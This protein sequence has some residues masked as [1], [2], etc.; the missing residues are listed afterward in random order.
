MSANLELTFQFI[1]NITTCMYTCTYIS[2]RLKT[3]ITDNW[4]DE[5]VQ[6]LNNIVLPCYNGKKIEYILRMA[7]Y[8]EAFQYIKKVPKWWSTDIQ[9]CPIKLPPLFRAPAVWVV[10]V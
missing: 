4:L 10:P 5:K 2:S 9:S 6:K 1:E 7:E 8:L 3:N